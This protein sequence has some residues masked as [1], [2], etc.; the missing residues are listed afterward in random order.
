MIKQLYELFKSN[1]YQL[2][3]VGGYVRDKILGIESR[4]IDLA[5]DARPEDMMEMLKEYNPKHI[6]FATVALYNVGKTVEVTT[7]RKKETYNLYS[8]TP[9]V[10]FGDSIFEDLMRRDFTINAMAWDIKKDVLID[11]FNGEKDLKNGILDTPGDAE[12]AFMD[13]PLRML[14]AIRFASEFGYIP[15]EMVDDEIVCL[16]DQLMYVSRERWLIEMDRILLGNYVDKALSGMWGLGISKYVLPEVEPMIDFKQNDEYH[17][18]DVWEHTLQVVSSC[19][20]IK[21]LRWAA[22]LHD[23]GKPRTYRNVNDE[24]HFYRH[25]EVG[26]KLVE[27]IG[28]RFKMS[29]EDIKEIKFLVAN[30]MRPMMYN[31]K[32]KDSAIRK[33]AIDAGRYLDNLLALSRADITSS[34]LDRVKEGM[35]N[36]DEL[37]NRIKNIKEEKIEKRLISREKMK[38]LIEKLDSGEGKWI[39]Q[40]KEKL[41]I[42]IA[43][44][45]LSADSTVGQLCNYVQNKMIATNF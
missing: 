20:K 31:I 19:P 30:H 43:D 21:N 24:I 15:S 18:K 23:V 14:R 3:I 16:C 28:S 37:E 34:K 35:S 29:N 42:A 41:E 12:E 33:L 32:W 10:E 22:L 9:D 40:M 5:T 45:E 26:E 27:V 25:E 38:E 13:D 39:G 36:I 17:C 1:G 6:G 4:D 7:F 8:R 2:Y 11:P 44:G